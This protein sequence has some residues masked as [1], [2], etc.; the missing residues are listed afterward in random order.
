MLVD[1]IQDSP[2]SAERV[3]PSPAAPLALIVEDNPELRVFIADV[4][5]VRYRVSAA[6][7]G[8]RGLEMAEQLR[9]DVIVSDVAMP[10][11]DGYELCR[12]LQETPH[13]KN[14]PVL[15]VTARTDVDS[16]IKGFEAG[17]S[18]YLLK[19]FHATE[20]LAR[21]DVHVQLRR[22][23]ALLARQERLAALGSLAASVAH[24][25]RN[26]LSALISGLPAIRGRLSPVIDRSS[27]ELMGV[28]LDCAERIEQMTLDLLDLSRIDRE[29][30]G[31]FAPGAGLLACT[32][33]FGP[34]LSS[35]IELRT[36]V[37]AKAQASGR[38]GDVNHVFMNVI[39][40]ALRAVGQKGVI[41]IR[42]AVDEE[43]YVVT[44]ADSGPG[45][46]TELLERIFEPFWTTRAA[47]E[48]TGLGLSIA[49]QIMDEHD[50]SIGASTSPLGGALI[51]IRLPL[52]VAER[53]V[54]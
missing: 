45:I 32:R 26:P 17:A 22:V 9:P 42:G 10:H 37:D 13:T 21:L 18:D 29:I 14:I 51:T 27:D 50:G 54:A 30:S 2:R 33:M 19:P 35:E 1:E 6:G 12:R 16:V 11:M 23:T 8:V 47:G 44:V 20:L 34:R 48:G 31:D 43:S 24:N 39:D 40:N 15:L 41:E 52:R 4:L 46:K 3:G 53:A 28:M 38:A 49:R 25:V 36:H 7:D 5:S